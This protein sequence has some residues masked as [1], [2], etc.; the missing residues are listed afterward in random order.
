MHIESH[1]S[2]HSIVYNILF[3]YTDLRLGALSVL[4]KYEYIYSVGAAPDEPIPLMRYI[5][6]PCCTEGLIPPALVALKVVK[7]TRHLLV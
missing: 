6:N 1:S 7:L 5:I 3:L 2:R 4:V